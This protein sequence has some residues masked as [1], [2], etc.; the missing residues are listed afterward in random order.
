MISPATFKAILLRELDNSGLKAKSFKELVSLILD[1]LNLDSDYPTQPGR[2]NLD[3][4]KSTT[5]TALQRAIFNGGFSILQ[6]DDGES[7]IEW[8]DLELPVTLSTFSRRKSVDLVGR[9]DNIPILC[10]LKVKGR[11]SG[12][13][14]NYAVLELAT[15][16]YFVL[17]NHLRLDAVEAHHRLERQDSFAWRDV[18]SDVPLLLVAA[19][20]RYWQ[21]WLEEKV[22]RD[23]FLR[24]VGNLNAKLRT[25]ICAFRLENVDFELQKGGKDTYM[26]TIHSKCW[27]Q[28]L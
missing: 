20:E 4:I 25:R 15:Y 26:P 28:I 11:A 2:P 6:F 12:D 23:R 10:E 14:P 7:V 5:E 21:Y 16:Y 3:R 8:L 18:V 9:V 22:Y 24:L 27:R 13:E 17:C 1:D 19:N